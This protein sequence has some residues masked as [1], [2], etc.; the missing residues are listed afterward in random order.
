MTLTYSSTP[1]ASQRAISREKRVAT[2]QSDRVRAIVV[3]TVL[4]LVEGAAVYM[5]NLH[6]FPVL[7]VLAAVCIGINIPLIG[8]LIQMFWREQKRENE[9]H[10]QWRY[11]KG[12]K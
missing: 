11:R 7:T 2:R 6:D 1:T 12:W 3:L 8:R 10:N 4:S 9:I 5:G